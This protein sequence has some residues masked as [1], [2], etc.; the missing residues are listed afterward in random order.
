MT[1]T[2]ASAFPVG[3]WVTSQIRGQIG[4]IIGVDGVAG[5][6]M[7]EIKYAEDTIS[8]FQS[9]AVCYGCGC[10]DDNSHASLCALAPRWRAEQESKPG[11]EPGYA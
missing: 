6:P 9:S 1:Q 3:A 11:H 8:I 2:E 5:L 10:G 4:E 7:Y